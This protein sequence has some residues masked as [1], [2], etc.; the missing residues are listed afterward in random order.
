MR[1]KFKIISLNKPRL[2][3]CKVHKIKREHKDKKIEIMLF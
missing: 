3:L 1:L 2:H